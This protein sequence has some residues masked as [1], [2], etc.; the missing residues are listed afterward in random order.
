MNAAAAASAERQAILRKIRR[1]KKAGAPLSNLA[2][3]T[4]EQFIL[5]R[6][7]RYNRRSG[8]LGKR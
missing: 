2:L 8:G 3:E 4:L 7:D 1:M 5:T 6:D